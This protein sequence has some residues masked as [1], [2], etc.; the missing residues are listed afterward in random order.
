[1]KM[2]LDDSSAIGSWRQSRRCD[3]SSPNC[4][5]VARHGATIAVRNST[6]P[7]GPAVL[8]TSAEMS[9]FMAGV[10]DGEFDDLFS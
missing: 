8:F 4:V 7:A 1:M 2:V 3:N 10:K 6:D 9:A 5:Q